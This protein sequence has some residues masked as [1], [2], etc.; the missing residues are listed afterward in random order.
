[1]VNA[2]RERPDLRNTWMRDPDEVTGRPA[3]RPNKLRAA[4]RGEATG[5]AVKDEKYRST[6]QTRTDTRK[7]VNADPKTQQIRARAEGAVP[8][9]GQGFPENGSVE[10]AKR[11]LK[12]NPP[13]GRDI[14][15]W[16]PDQ[17]RAF[18]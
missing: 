10:D 11:Y 12:E 16:T 5:S 2:V 9:K 3:P 17:R 6:M 8:P 13:A 7:A 1:M 14:A 15:S 18:N 4:R